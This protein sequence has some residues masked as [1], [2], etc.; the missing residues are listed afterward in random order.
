MKKESDGYSRVDSMGKEGN[1]VQTLS[2]V[3]IYII[4]P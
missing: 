1:R 2:F 3:I 4:L